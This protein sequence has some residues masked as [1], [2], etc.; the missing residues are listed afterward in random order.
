RNNYS[1]IKNRYLIYT[2]YE[3]QSSLQDYKVIFLEALA[4]ISRD[5][6]IVVNGKLPQADINRLA[7]FGKVLERDNEGYD[8]AA[9]RHGIIHTGKEALQQYN[10]LILVND[11][12]I[13]PFRDL[14]EVFSEFN[15][16]Q[17]DF[18]GISMGE[19]QLDFT[20]YN[21]YGKIPK[22]LQSYF[23]V[24]EN[25]LLR[26]EGFYDYWEKLS[27]TD[28]R[29]KAI[30]KHETVFAKYFYD[31]GFKY[32]ALIKDT[33]DSALYIHPFKLLKQGCPLV[34]YSAF[35]NY[36]REQ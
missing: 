23:V 13:G 2:I 27:D 3:H 21:P 36:D 28:S 30:G 14:E 15:S 29:N 33:K 26:Y 20:G 17:L 12:N 31:R 5:V 7:Q 8:V 34:K 18:W 9:F 24:I 11:T 16:D 6:L 1:D 25:S 10:Q 32:D 4:K 35:R 19:E 22:H